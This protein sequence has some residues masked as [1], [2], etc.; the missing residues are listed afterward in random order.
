MRSSEVWDEGVARPWR[1]GVGREVGVME[2][3]ERLGGL[4]GM[5]VGVGLWAKESV[6]KSERIEKAKEGKSERIGKATAWRGG[7]L[8]CIRRSFGDIC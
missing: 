3:G 2:E 1:A 6:E 8:V 4:E 5:E 7:C